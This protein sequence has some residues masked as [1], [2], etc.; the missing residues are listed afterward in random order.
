[1][2]DEQTLLYY[3]QYGRIEGMAG[4]LANGA[5]LEARGGHYRTALHYAAMNGYQNAVAWLLEQGADPSAVDEFGNTPL[6]L[7]SKGGWMA[8][9]NLLSLD[10]AEAA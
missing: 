7:A 3:A 5:S 4:A 1:M 8:S 6:D 2:N 9:V 10:S